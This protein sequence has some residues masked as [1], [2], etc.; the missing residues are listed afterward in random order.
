MLG[1]TC[2]YSYIRYGKRIVLARRPSLSVSA[3]CKRICGVAKADFSSFQN[4]KP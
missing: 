1:L 3:I 4:Q 2:I